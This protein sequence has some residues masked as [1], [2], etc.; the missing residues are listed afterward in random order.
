MPHKLRTLL[1]AAVLF[2]SPR[3]GNFDIYRASLDA[4][5]QEALK[6][7]SSDTELA[8][9]LAAG[10]QTQVP[11]PQVAGAPGTASSALASA[12]VAAEP[13]GPILSGI[14]PYVLALGG[15]AAAWVVVEAILITR[16]RRTRRR[17]MRTDGQ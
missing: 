4:N 5:G 10:H 17:T 6:R 8:P 2:A 16:R 15:L 11:L 7:V 3:N 12:P 14:S 13:T 9:A 1:I